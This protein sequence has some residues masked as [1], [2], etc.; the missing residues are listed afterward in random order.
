MGQEDMIIDFYKYSTL[1]LVKKNQ[2]EEILKSEEIVL[3]ELE[4]L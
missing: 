2:L 3:G 4:K 1:V